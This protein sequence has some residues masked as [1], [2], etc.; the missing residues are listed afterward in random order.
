METKKPGT[1][2]EIVADYLKANGYDGLCC[3][4]CGCGLG[5]HFMPCEER[6]VGCK[7][8]YAS[9]QLCDECAAKESCEY[10]DP[11][12]GPQTCYSTEKVSFK[13]KS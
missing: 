3:D 12:I 4:G 2:K 7:P 8:A 13:E 9:T 1:V 6:F 5:D 11:K 10:V